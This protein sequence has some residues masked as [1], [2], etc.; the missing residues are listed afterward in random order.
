[1]ESL[2]SYSYS[3][4]DPMSEQV[5]AQ[6]TL[7]KWV[8]FEF[9]STDWFWYMAIFPETFY[10]NTL[11]G[12]LEF[13]TFPILAIVFSFGLSTN[14]MVKTM[15]LWFIQLMLKLT[16]WAA[17]MSFY[18]FGLAIFITWLMIPWNA[19]FTF[20]ATP[21]LVPLIIFKLVNPEYSQY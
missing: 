12:P 3:L 4:S 21:V 17:P 7:L 19:I 6:Q 9:F 15:G 10:Y 18:N 11:L 16:I 13:F 8:N 20:V 2:K 1:M 5:V 14:W